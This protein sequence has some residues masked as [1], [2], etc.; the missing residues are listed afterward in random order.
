MIE[1]FGGGVFSGCNLVL[2]NNEVY[3]NTCTGMNNAEANGGGVLLGSQSR[4]L[5]FKIHNNFIHD[6]F[7]EGKTIVGA[8]VML[9]YCKGSFTGNAI[10]NNTGIAVNT[11]LGGGMHL[12]GATG[13]TEITGNDFAFNSLEGYHVQGGGIQIALADD[14]MNVFN[15]SFIQNML[16]GSY[17]AHGGGLVI[18]QNQEVS[19]INN[20]FQENVLQGGSFSGAGISGHDP[21]ARTEIRNNTF[22]SNSGSGTGYGG[23]IGYFSSNNIPLEIDGNVFENNSIMAGGGLYTY[24]CYNSLIYNNIFSGNSA[25][26]MGGGCRFRYNAG[27]PGELASLEDGLIIKNYETKAIDNRSID[28]PMVM[29]NTFINNTSPMGGAIYSD[30]QDEFPLIV[31]SI[32]RGNIAGT[33]SDIYHAGSQNLTVSYTDIDPANVHG[34][35]EGEGNILADPLFIDPENGNFCIDTCSSPCLAAGIDSIYLSDF[36]YHSPDHDIRIFPRPF[37]DDSSPDMGAYE[38]YCSVGLK[39][40]RTQNSKLRMELYPNPSP[41]IVDCQFSIFNIQRVTMKVY[42]VHGRE[43]SALH[44]KKLSE[45]EHVVW[46]DL[47][48]LPDGIYFIR[49]QA[50]DRIMTGKVVKAK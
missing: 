32:F 39:E 50:G 14:T 19:I 2:E 47:G 25:T 37:P 23:G 3:G 29:N 40:R 30:H 31:N 45:G 33:G 46:F 1:A 17:Q 15:N 5:I 7:C 12:N 21:Y 48:G 9:W 36:W 28:H 13:F 18:I 27:K 24:N 43:V 49:L 22:D 20:L 34:P 41:G 16:Y 8:G 38:V 26:Q 11:A 35:W 6:N 4:T 44:D 42:D 10:R